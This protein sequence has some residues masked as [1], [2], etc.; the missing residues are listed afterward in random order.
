LLAAPRP[1]GWHFSRRLARGF[2]ATTGI[3]SSSPPV[4]TDG[5]Y[6]LTFIAQNG[7][8]SEVTQSFTFVVEQTANQHFV[9]NVYKDL[10]G[11]APDSGGLAFWSGLL[12]L[13]NSRATILNLF[14][15]GS[16]YFS[17][18]IKSAYQQYL[19]RTGDSGGLV[20]W[21]QQ[22]INGVTDEQ[23]EASLIASAEYYKHASGTDQGWVD[24]M[25]Q[26][27]LGRQPDSLG[28]KFWT[29]QLAGGVSRSSAAYGFAVSI[30]RERHQIAA[31]YKKFLGRSGAPG[32]TLCCPV[33]DHQAVNVPEALILGNENVA[34]RL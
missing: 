19:G 34:P 23:L 2:G 7:V 13:G 20:F 18:I 14:D 24:A 11:H 10:L 32:P 28:E 1:D 5:T 31:D 17:P 15:H 8:G 22:M 3:L 16:W 33:F 21:I 27:L 9:S 29:Q 4:G 25:Y 26:D 6:S 12:D 30:E